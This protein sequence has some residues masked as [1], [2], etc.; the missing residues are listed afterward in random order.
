VELDGEQTLCI[1]GTEFSG[2]YVGSNGYI[3]FDGPDTSYIGDLFTHFCMKRISALFNDLDPSVR[4]TVSWKQF[5][6]RV[7][8]TWQNVP[9]RGTGNHNTFQ[10]EMYFDGTIRLAWLEVDAEACLVGI[11]DGRGLPVD[12]YETDFSQYGMCEQ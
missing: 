1:Y 2:F 4:G 8:V 7:V 10:V 5:A 9:Q 12:V 3:T 11:S 6:D